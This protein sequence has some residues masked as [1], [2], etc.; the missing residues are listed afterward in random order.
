MH[1]TPGAEHA[2]LKG[3]V[4]TWRFEVEGMCEPGKPPEKSVGRETVRM[5]GDYWAVFE[6]EMDGPGGVP[7]RSLMTLGYDPARGKYVGTWV[8]SPMATLFVYEGERSAD[9]TTLPLNTSGPSWADPSKTS[10][11]QDVHELRGDKRVLWSQAQQDD[12]TWV[13]FMRAEYVR[14]G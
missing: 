9:G 1:G 10:A 13:K 12:G 3:F 2:W 7:M 5:L 14:E 8:G 4:G 11:Y 6:G